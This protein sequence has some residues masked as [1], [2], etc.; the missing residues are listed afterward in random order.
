[1][2]YRKL[3]RNLRQ[4]ITDYYEHRYQGKMFDED[5]ILA[6]LNECLKEVS[7]RS[8]IYAQKSIVYCSCDG[9][10]VMFFSNFF[11]GTWIRNICAY[12]RVVMTFW[13]LPETS[14]QKLVIQ[15]NHCVQF[16]DW[17]VHCTNGNIYYNI[18]LVMGGCDMGTCLDYVKL[19]WLIKFAV[20][21]V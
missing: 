18:L 4:R 17:Y 8:S 13:R 16:V 14:R 5:S 21:C 12:T 11:K 15:V 7:G 1:M 19:P 3:P 20:S 9:T 2:V 6:E 10:T